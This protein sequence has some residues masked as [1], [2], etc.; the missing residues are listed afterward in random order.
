MV[1]NWT[2]Q[3]YLRSLVGSSQWQRVQLCICIFRLRPRTGGIG[4]A[5]PSQIF[6][7]QHRWTMHVPACSVATGD[8]LH[9]DIQAQG[10]LGSDSS[11]DAAGW[12]A[13]AFP[14]SDCHLSDYVEDIG[15]VTHAPCSRM[16]LRHAEQAPLH[17]CCSNEITHIGAQL[18]FQK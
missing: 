7:L 15:I 11:M 12:R 9:F 10:A 14:G 4:R 16:N 5:G 3:Y 6:K 2:A 1:A 13:P 18:A 17:A 8:A